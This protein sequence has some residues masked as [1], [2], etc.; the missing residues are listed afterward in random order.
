MVLGFGGF[1][2]LG[3]TVSM[4]K[5]VHSHEVEVWFLVF[6]ILTFMSRDVS[7]SSIINQ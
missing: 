4:K 6:T 3:D 5:T 1:A 2:D 7:L